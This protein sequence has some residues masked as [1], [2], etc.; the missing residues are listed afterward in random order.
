MPLMLPA[1]TGRRPTDCT[2]RKQGHCNARLITVGVSQNNAR[3]VC[4]GFQNRADQRVEFGIHQHHG[5]AVLKC[6]EYYARAKIDGPR[7]F[8]D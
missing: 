6:V 2:Y 1:A 4:L 8:N 3:L 5:L 7:H